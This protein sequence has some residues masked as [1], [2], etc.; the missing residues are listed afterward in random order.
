MRAGREVG[1]IKKASVSGGLKTLD[2][3]NHI[4]ARTKIVFAYLVDFMHQNT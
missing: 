1:Q 4:I 2:I 3:I